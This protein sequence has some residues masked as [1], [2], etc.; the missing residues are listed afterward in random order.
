MAFSGDLAYRWSWIVRLAI[1][2]LPFKASI[3]SMCDVFLC[4]NVYIWDRLEISSRVA[5]STIEIQWRRRRVFNHKSTESYRLT[6]FS[7]WN[8]L[9]TSW[10]KEVIAVGSVSYSKVA[11]TR[12]A[13]FYAIIQSNY[14]TSSDW[15]AC[16]STTV[17]EAPGFYFF[18]TIPV[19]T[20]VMRDSMFSSELSTGS[21]LRFDSVIWTSSSLKPATR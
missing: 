20:D 7:Y 5:F 9:R 12:G 11:S 1:S 13:S 3:L 18:P 16:L 21:S 17:S 8:L 10:K 15:S 19:E 4:M 14:S 6:D 2:S